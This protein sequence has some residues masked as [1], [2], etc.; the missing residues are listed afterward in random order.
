MPRKYSGEQILLLK[1]LKDLEDFLPYLVLV[2]GWVPFLYSRYL[3]TDMNQ[4]PLLTRDID[5]GLKNTPY[6]GNETIADRVTRKKYGEHHLEI[7]KDIPFVPVV[8]SEQGTQAEI[9]FISDAKT[10]DAISKKLV[11]REILVNKLPFVDI[12]LRKTIPVNVDG[13]FVNI[14]HP[15][16]YVF[17]KI[18]TFTER[19]TSSKKGKDLYY[20]YYVLRFDPE[21]SSLIKEIQQMVLNHPQ[22]SKVAENIKSYFKDPFSTGPG[23]I[24]EESKMSTLGTLGIDIRKDAFEKI[25][26]VLGEF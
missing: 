14:P 4:E 13:I 15:A 12:L 7:G 22:G 3:W 5:F 19:P 20:A 2:G 10:S 21:S 1:V 18:L 16:G 24:F 9:E 17:H 6:Q 25:H 26:S 11:G 23:M 8:K